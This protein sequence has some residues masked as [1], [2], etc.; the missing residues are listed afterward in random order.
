MKCGFAREIITPKVGV[1]LCGYFD[2]RP[3]DGAFDELYIRVLALETAEGGKCAILS[4]DV[5]FIAHDL[6]ERCKAEMAKAGIDWADQVIFSATHSHTA[7]LPPIR[8]ASSGMIP[9]KNGF[10]HLPNAVPLP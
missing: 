5:C 9:M 6:I 1:P 2:P 10:R 4:A 7:T 8:T 3:N